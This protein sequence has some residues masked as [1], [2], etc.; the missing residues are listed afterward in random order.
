MHD[1]IHNPP[2]E[3][4]STPNE[5]PQLD[6]SIPGASRLWMNTSDGPPQTLKILGRFADTL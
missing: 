4:T 2:R 5:L 1:S 6:R 3:P